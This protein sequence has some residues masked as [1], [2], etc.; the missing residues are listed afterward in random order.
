M[1][2]ETGLVSLTSPLAELL[3][4]KS[5]LA[6][7][8]LSFHDRLN[9]GL[10]VLM[11]RRGPWPMGLSPLQDS[12]GGPD[13]PTPPPPTTVLTL[14]LHQANQ[15]VPLTPRGS[16]LGFDSQ[17][18]SP[19]SPHVPSQTCSGQAVQLTLRLPAPSERMTN[20]HFY[21]CLQEIR[22]AA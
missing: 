17:P 6:K 12:S 11:G 19:A 21:P 18:F 4:A 13:F 10:L 15:G 5:D 8:T 3:G 14:S 16:S 22:L 1:Q 7:G 20:G 9:C 2:K